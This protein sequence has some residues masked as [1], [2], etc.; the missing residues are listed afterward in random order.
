MTSWLGGLASQDLLQFGAISFPNSE[1]AAASQEP[2]TQAGPEGMGW[3][4]VPGSAFC[5]GSWS[6]GTGPSAET[7]EFVH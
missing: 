6:P 3:G 7:L 2:W 5:T 1:S 4:D